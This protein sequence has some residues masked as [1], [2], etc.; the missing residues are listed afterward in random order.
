MRDTDKILDLIDQLNAALA[1]RGKLF[2][3]RHRVIEHFKL[4]GEKGDARRWTEMHEEL[5]TETTRVDAIRAAL[6]ALGS[7]S[8]PLAGDWKGKTYTVAEALAVAP[9]LGA[10]GPVSDHKDGDK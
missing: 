5:K 6:E 2:E 7:L 1:R 10:R 9:V 8:S 3:E 4:T